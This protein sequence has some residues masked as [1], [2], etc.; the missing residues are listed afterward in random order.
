MSTEVDVSIP[1]RYPNLQ[2]KSNSAD[3]PPEPIGFAVVLRVA[4]WSSCA[5]RRYGH[6]VN[7]EG[8]RDSP[9]ERLEE[10]PDLVRDDAGPGGIG[11]NAVGQHEIRIPEHAQHDEGNERNAIPFCEAFVRT[12]KRKRIRHSVDRRRFH[13]AQNDRDAPTLRGFDDATE[14]DRQILHGVAA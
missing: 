12:M 4:S 1:P 6:L 2:R 11:M 14:I 5:I 13:A 9:Q 7:R 8:L 3:A 10:R